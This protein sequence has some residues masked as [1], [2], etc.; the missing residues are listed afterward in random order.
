MK[1]NIISP[2]GCH[3]VLLT[4]KNSYFNESPGPRIVFNGNALAIEN[5]FGDKIK[6]Y[7]DTP[8][9]FQT[10]EWVTVKVHFLFSETNNGLY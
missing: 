5:K 3:I 9:A 6:Y 10:G 4:M 8:V 7:Q 2:M 1:Q